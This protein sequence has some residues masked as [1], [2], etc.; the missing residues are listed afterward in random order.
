MSDP[1][2]PEYQQPS[3]PPT[4]PGPITEL[5]GKASWPTIIGIIAIVFGA[6]GMLGALLGSASMIFGELLTM[7][8]IFGQPAMPEGGW[9]LLFAALLAVSFFV[10]L[11]LLF[12]G[13][14]LNYRLKRGARLCKVWAVTKVILVVISTVLGFVNAPAT[15]RE[16]MAAQPGGSPPFGDAFIYA[17]MG[18]GICF[19]LVWGWALP[20]FM[21]IWFSRKKIKA[22]VAE[23]P[24]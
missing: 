17:M 8:G 11:M 19:G 24:Q 3:A 7:P 16:A 14:Y 6:G 12:G 10:A 15:M 18:V 13:I 21:L 20:V 23:W 2:E 22:E 4:A 5:R 9:R 1:I